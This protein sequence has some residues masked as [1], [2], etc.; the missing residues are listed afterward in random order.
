[1]VRCSKI[2]GGKFVSQTKGLRTWHKQFYIL[3]PQEV[4]QIMD[5]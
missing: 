3:Q 2:I 5:G 1:M 4:E